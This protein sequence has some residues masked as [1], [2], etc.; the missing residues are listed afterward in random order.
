MVI[1]WKWCLRL[2]QI[3]LG[4]LKITRES[5][6]SLLSWL[7]VSQFDFPVFNLNSF[8]DMHSLSKWWYFSSVTRGA[9]FLPLPYGRR[10]FSYSLISLT[11]FI[12]AAS[13]EAKPL[14]CD[15]FCAVCFLSILLDRVHLYI[16]K[17]VQMLW[18][19]N[20]ETCWVLSHRG[21]NCTPRKR[22]WHEI[23]IES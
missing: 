13:K 2:L 14:S 12:V 1:A 5:S 17:D 11:V 21:S 19:L 10:L 3:Q 16:Y 9:L 15:F 4:V 8:T 20:E 23:I 22:T 18:L 6:A 7:G